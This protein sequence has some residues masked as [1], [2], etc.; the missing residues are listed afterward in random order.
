MLCNLYLPLEGFLKLGKFGVHAP[1]T[2]SKSATFKEL[3]E[4]FTINHIHRIFVVN[5]DGT[6][7]SVISLSDVLTA[8]AN[9]C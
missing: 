5:E 6:P 9:K 7:S 3:L 4:A 8:I 2:I 1:I